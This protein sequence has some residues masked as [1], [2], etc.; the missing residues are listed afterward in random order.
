MDLIKRFLSYTAVDTQSDENSNTVPSTEK[1][2]NLARMLKAELEGMGLEDVVMDD[3]GYVYATLPANTDEDIPVIGFISHMDTSPSMSG[4]DVK[5]RIVENYDGGDIILNA[6]QGVVLSP[7]LFPELLAHKGEDLIVTDGTTLLGADDKAGIAEIITAVEYLQQ[8]P[9]IKHGK[10]RIGFNPDEE[11]GM[12]ADNF[13]VELFGCD[14]AYTVDGG[15]VGEM[16]YE[17]FNAAKAVFRIQGLE[18]HP[19]YAK[20]K[21]VNASLLAAELIGMFPAG[22][23]PATTSGYEGFYHIVGLS[24]EVDHAVVTFIIRDHDRDRFE[25]RKRFAESVADSMNAKY[26]AGTVVAEVSDQYYNMKQE[27]DKVPHVVEIA[28]RAMEEAGV[29]PVKVPIRGGTDGAQLSFKGLPCPNLF[30]G[31]MNFHGR[32]EWIPVQSMEKSVLTIVNIA[33]G[34]RGFASLG[35]L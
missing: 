6:E 8:H 12:G 14:W 27:I 21:M 13:N 15:E 19:G 25:E 20:G 9:E 23:T 26:G 29:T 34:A 32:Y 22:E 16:E 3:M 11:I 17:N 30:A 2:K 18:V 4:K 7:S 10:V 35:F 24:G 31:G 33:A 1:Q 28:C 5:P